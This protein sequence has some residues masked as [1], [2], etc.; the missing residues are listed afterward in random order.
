MLI[1]EKVIKKTLEVHLNPTRFFCADFRRCTCDPMVLTRQDFN[2]TSGAVDGRSR[3]RRVPMAQGRRV[4]ARVTQETA[5]R[6]SR[7]TVARGRL[8]PAAPVNQLPA[9]RWRRVPM[10]GADGVWRRQHSS[11]RLSRLTKSKSV[12][13]PQSPHDQGAT[14]T[15]F[16]LWKQTA[17][18]VV[19]SGMNTEIPLTR[20]DRRVSQRV[21]VGS[22]NITTCCRRVKVEE[23]LRHNALCTPSSGLPPRPLPRGV[24]DDEHK[25][26][27]QDHSTT[28]RRT[29]TSWRSVMMS[30]WKFWHTRGSRLTP[31]VHGCPK[32]EAVGGSPTDRT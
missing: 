25:W 32:G 22:T 28:T 5:A 19:K 1:L 29:A 31:T 23:V 4:P 16:D 10:K 13:T 18:P 14:T 24:W 20:P 26:T 30:P 2:A 17:K 7:V 6:A 12:A 21:H 9:V 3:Q 8:V 11:P 27:R 15:T